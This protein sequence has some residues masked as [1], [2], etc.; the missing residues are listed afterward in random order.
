LPKF[1]AHAWVISFSSRPKH[2]LDGRL[3]EVLPGTVFAWIAQLRRRLQEHAAGWSW[4]CT[5][6]DVWGGG[7]G[8]RGHLTHWLYL[9]VGEGGKGCE[10]EACA[11]GGDCTRSLAAVAS[12]CAGQVPL[13]RYHW[14]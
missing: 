4:L 14:V 6:L 1:G 2:A 12:L 10:G 9:L 13:V 11:Q 8:H 5:G 3:Q 7:A